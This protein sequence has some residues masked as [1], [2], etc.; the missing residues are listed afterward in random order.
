MT[1]LAALSLL[2]LQ[3]APAAPPAVPVERAV[4]DAFRQACEAVTDWERLRA[5]APGLGWEA[6]AENADS[7]LQ[8]VVQVG[9]EAVGTEGRYT[10][11]NFRRTV[12][13]RTLYLAISRWEG[14][15]MWGNGCRLYDFAA[16]APIDPALLASWMGREP[17]GRQELGPTVGGNLL[18]EPGWRDGLTVSVNHVPATSLFR[19]RYGLSGN[20]FVAQALGEM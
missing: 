11:Q 14:E 15:G 8:R 9:R 1:F 2:A 3:P 17:T 19:E 12:A 5:G 6:V 16:A 13:G 18:W 20:V 7:Q 4:L 10:A